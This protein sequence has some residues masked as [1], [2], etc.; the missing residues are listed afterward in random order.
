M[1]NAVDNPVPPARSSSLNRALVSSAVPKPANIRIV[2][3]RDRYIVGWMP[4]VYGYSPGN[5]PSPYAASTGTPD[6]VSRS[7]IPPVCQI[8]GYPTIGSAIVV[9]NWSFPGG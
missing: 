1:S 4:R 7:V 3:N 2:H 6:M 9:A 8:L 5:G